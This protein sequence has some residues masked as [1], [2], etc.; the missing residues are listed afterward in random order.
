[1]YGHDAPRPGTG[2]RPRTP[3]VTAGFRWRPDTSPDGVDHRQHDQ[4]ER[5]GDAD[6]RDG[7]AV[8]V[9]DDDR[10]RSR[11]TPGRTCRRTRPPAC[12]TIG[13]HRLGFSL[14]RVDQLEIR[15]RWPRPHPG[16]A[17]SVTTIES[18]LLFDQC[19]DQGTGVIVARERQHAGGQREQDEHAEHRQHG[20]QAK[21]M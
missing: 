15:R 16:P 14:R 20:E 19:L 3:S 2:R 4:P 13:L 17:A 9:V 7:A 6:V 11:R 21:R 10:P 5:Q 18:L 8:D 1:M 12:A